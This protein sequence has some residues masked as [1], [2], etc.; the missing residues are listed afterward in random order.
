MQVA[1]LMTPDPIAIG[2]REP[3]AIAKAI[4][5]KGG[6]RRLPVVENGNL[7]GI[8][9]ERDMREHSGYLESTLVDA[10]M[11][12][13]LITVAPSD[14]VDDAARLMLKYKI[15]GLPVIA[16]GRLAGIVTATDLLRA[17]LTMLQSTRQIMRG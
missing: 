11:R 5:D 17:F 6:F 14:S 4:M 8:L 9:T 10:A 16:E 12:T 3:L 7:I 2:P 15:G 13:K 1:K